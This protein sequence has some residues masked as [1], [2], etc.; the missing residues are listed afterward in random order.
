MADHSFR[1]SYVPNVAEVFV[2]KRGWAL[3]AQT[4]DN[5][6]NRVAVTDD[7]DSSWLQHYGCDQRGSIG[8]V[9]DFRGQI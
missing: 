8:G 5:V 2:C 3:P 4:S 9:V 1:A 7:K 6:W